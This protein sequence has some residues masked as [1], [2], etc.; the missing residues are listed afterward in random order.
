MSFETAEKLLNLLLRCIN[1]SN[2][3]NGY[4]LFTL[5]EIMSIVESTALSI[6]W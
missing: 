5:I 1:N 4:S 6:A 2:V 3:T